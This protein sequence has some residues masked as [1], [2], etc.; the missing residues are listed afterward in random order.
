MKASE[1][2]DLRSALAFLKD[3]PGQLHE[4]NVAVDP[5]AELSGVYRYIGAGG[6]VMRPTGAGPAMLFHNVKGHPDAS[7]LIGLLASRSRAALLLDT[8]PDRLGFRLAQSLAHPIP[9]EE[10]SC[11]PCQEVVHTADEPD[12]DL[13]TLV[14]APTNTPDDAGPY[15]TMGLC[16]ATHPETGKSDVTIHR[17]CIQGRDTLSIF[18]TPGSRHIGAM[19]ARASELGI[20]L[21][22]SVSIGV[23]PAISIG[24]CFEPP[25]APMGF[26]ELTVAGA[27]RGR[28]VE[29]VRCLTVD[30]RAIARAEYVIEGE[31]LPGETIREDLTTGTGYAMPEFTGYTGAACRNCSVIRVRA[32]THRKHP[33]LQ[34]CI[35]PSEEHVTMMGIPTE[36]SIIGMIERAM[37]GRL[38]NVYMPSCGGGKYLCVLQLRKAQASDEGRQRQAALLAFSAFSELKHVILVDEDVDPFDLSDVLWAMNT[39]YQGDMDTVFLPAVHCHVLDPSACPDYNPALPQKGVSC[40][41]IFDCTVPYHLQDRFRRSAFL[42][43]PDWK[44]YL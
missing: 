20:P 41:V 32:V 21:P 36:A 11:A 5:K 12:F 3:Q 38:K 18:F 6:T 42:E 1:I 9:T 31:I 28:P 29:L 16:Y 10:I 26:D 4:T 33:V 19:A 40:K 7:V 14:P 23:D 35:G 39:R 34:T 22:I 13:R 2:N 17:L 37:P 44:K 30:E 43:V 8:E 25:A 24:A 15:L 27:L